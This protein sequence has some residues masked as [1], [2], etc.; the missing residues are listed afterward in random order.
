MKLYIALIGTRGIPA[1]YGGFETCVEEVGKRLAAKGHRVTVY[2][3]NTAKSNT[4]GIYLGMK[5][6]A[7]PALKSKSLE[8]LSNTFLSVG[9]AL[10][11]NFDVYMLFNAANA[12]FVLPLWALFKKVAMNTDG[13]EWQRTKWGCLGKTYYRLSEKVACIF[14]NRLIAD[15]VG[16]HDYYLSRHHTDS[17]NIAY[18]ADVPAAGSAKMI[19]DL[20]LESGKY[21][22][23]ITRFEPENHPLLTIEAFTR[24]KTDKK[25]VLVG[26]N[27]YQNPYVEKIYAH[28]SDTI[29][30]PGFV[31]DADMLAALWGHAF[32][33]VHGNSIG[34]TNP[35]LLQA[36]A[37]GCYT[38]AYD[39]PFN[40]EVLQDC[41]VYYNKNAADLAAKMSQAIENSERLDVFRQ[42]AKQRILDHYSWDA[43]ADQYEELFYQLVENK[44][45]WRLNWRALIG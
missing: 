23:Q 45:P 14:T 29:R 4:S 42:R 22:L 15:S 3:R 16:I 37:A 11:Q 32:A 30:L 19:Q 21:F 39:V 25:L 6:V 43:V 20:G 10:M 1:R 34:G 24:I 41:G 40:R 7:L 17:T 27:P 12:P 5:R 44:F 35:A 13:L 9:H 33:Y 36:M 18:G 38:I 31:Y 28:A 2:C 26:G 8:T